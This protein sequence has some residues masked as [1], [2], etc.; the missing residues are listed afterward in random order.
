MVNDLVPLLEE[1]TCNLRKAAGF[2]SIQQFAVSI[3]NPSKFILESATRTTNS[4]A[5][6]S[7]STLVKESSSDTGTKVS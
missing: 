3:P 5:E 2:L 7:T 4:M 1:S 6:A